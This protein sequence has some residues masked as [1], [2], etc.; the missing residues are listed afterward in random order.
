MPTSGQG[1]ARSF[2]RRPD[3]PTLCADGESCAGPRRRVGR[4][5]QVMRSSDHHRRRVPQF[6]SIHTLG[7]TSLQVTG[8]FGAPCNDRPQ[9]V[10]PSSTATRHPVPT[11]SPSLSTGMAPTTLTRLHPTFYVLPRRSPRDNGC[12][13]RKGKAS[14]VPRDPGASCSPPTPRPVD[15]MRLLLVA[16]LPAPGPLLT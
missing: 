8:V 14:D 13:A 9:D 7:M 2:V 15:N 4:R 10:L 11:S 3:R 6:F 16:P 5:R 12:G 1:A